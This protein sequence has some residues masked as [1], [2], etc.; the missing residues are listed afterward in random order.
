MLS[1]VRNE[2]LDRIAGR[3]RQDLSRVVEELAR[4]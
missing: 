2:G 3:V 1:I 4:G